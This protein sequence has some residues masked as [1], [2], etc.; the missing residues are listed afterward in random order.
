M[1]QSHP[2][3][4]RRIVSFVTF[5]ELR[6]LWQQL[7]LMAGKSALVV[8]DSDITDGYIKK[9]ENTRQELFSLLLSPVLNALLRGQTIAETNTY[10]LSIS[11]DHEE[12]KQ[13]ID[14]NIEK[15]NSISDLNNHLT[16]KTLSIDL[17]LLNYLCIQLFQLLDKEQ[18]REHDNQF[19][20]ICEPVSL[21]LQNQIAQEK[22]LNQVIGQIRQSLD[23]SVIL[24]TAVREVRSLL[25]V[26][27]LVIYQFAYEHKRITK[28]KKDQQSW[29]KVTYESRLSKAIPS[30][31]NLKAEDDCFTHV[32]R[33]QEKYSQ[34]M[35]VDIEDVESAY[36][37]SFCLI[38]FLQQYWI[39]SKL[40]APIVIDGQLWG[41]LIAHQC[42]KKRKWLDKEKEF[43]GK[44]GEH[45]AVA[46]YQAQLYS[47]VQQQKNSF[48]QRVIERTQALR[49]TLL[50]AQAANQSKTEFLG[51]MSHEL[52]TPL[53]CIIGLSGTLLHWSNTSNSLPIDKQKQYLDTIQDS[54]KHLLQLINEILEFSQLEAG[55]TVLNIQ[56]FSL[57]QLAYQVFQVL[58][59]EADK[60][61]IHLA[62]DLRVA[63]ENNIFWADPE[64]L[65]Q[66][67][68]QLMNNAIKFTP[69]GG[70]V[71]LR[72]WR[73]NN[74]AFFQVEDTGIGI[75]DNQIPLLFETF[76]QLEN[77][78]H[79]TYGGTGLGLALTKQLVELH[80]GTIE[81]ES[82]IKQGSIFTV[83]IPSQYNNY[84]KN[85]PNPKKQET[86]NLSNQGVILI[87]KDEELATLI[88]ELLTTANYQV[89]WLLE[90]TNS[91]KTIEVLR[92]AL[93]ILSQD[94]LETT[95]FA[96]QLKRSPTTKS[97]KTLLISQQMS[98][99]HWEQLA[100]QGI[101]DYLLQ[102]IDPNLLLKRVNTLS[103]NGEQL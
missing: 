67:L 55:K 97:V 43:L 76:Q 42:F 32:A 4:L 6:S 69:S 52:R 29:G 94:T 75:A 18:E 72:T 14:Q 90:T 15:L 20:N 70:E 25:E 60:Q 23:L 40:I 96:Q 89:I 13:W 84:F 61:S 98:A 53:T 57:K 49:D 58:K 33:Y 86:E 102:P 36:S 56:E 100:Q 34:G 26:D 8:T 3:I 92:P 30:M 50:A 27:R 95:Q 45:L 7:G 85:S 62:L 80:Q 88:C 54:G 35:I 39:Q 87:E 2:L 93:V 38:E 51:N 9:H 12:I 91:S 103:N 71:T 1:S 16:L 99:S 79:R 19:L 68:Y 73:E 46:I 24:E 28:R 77:Y 63:P 41:L 66:I 59:E 78:R 44:I 37:S 31:L 74:Q 48:E 65:Q 83:A 64:R 17:S 81:V 10:Q 101:D 22:L 21:A 5:E 47:Q 11:W 82:I